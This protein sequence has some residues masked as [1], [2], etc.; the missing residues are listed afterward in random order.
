MEKTQQAIAIAS[1]FLLR[2]SSSLNYRKAC[3]SNNLSA[4]VASASDSD[5]TSS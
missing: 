5:R 2:A 4:Q 3:V 1:D